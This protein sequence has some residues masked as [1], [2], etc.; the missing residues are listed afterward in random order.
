MFCIRITF[1]ILNE[2]DETNKKDDCKKSIRYYEN[3]LKLAINENKYKL[4]FFFGDGTTLYK[5]GEAYK[6]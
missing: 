5:D 6:R 3:D 4:K 2:A 1:S